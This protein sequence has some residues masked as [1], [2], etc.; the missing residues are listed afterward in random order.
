MN[1]TSAMRAASAWPGPEEPAWIST[2]WPCGERGTLS[3]PVTVKYLPLEVR[4]VEAARPH[5]EAGRLVGD[6]GIV[7]P[8]VPQD[9]AGLDELLGHGIALGMRRMLAAEHRGRLVVGRRHHVPRR[10]AAAER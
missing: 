3:A 7:V 2:G 6:E 9:A 4:H 8:A 10:A 1:T 5:E